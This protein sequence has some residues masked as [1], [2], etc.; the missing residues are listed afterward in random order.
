MMDVDEYRAS[1]LSC[2][3]IAKQLREMPLDELERGIDL[4]ET[5]GPFAD[6][7]LW[8]QK[9]RALSE[10]KSVVEILA[11]AKRALDK[12]PWPAR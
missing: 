4:A 11:R 3:A 6:P 7:T 9:S 5:V 12:L 1:L 8:M 10:D 2:Y